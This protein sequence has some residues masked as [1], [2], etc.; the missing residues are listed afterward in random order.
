MENQNRKQSQYLL[1]RGRW[2]GAGLALLLV[3]LAGC[4]QDIPSADQSSSG[5]SN[6]T[7]QE[8]PEADAE[9]PQSPDSAPEISPGEN[10]NSP[11][12]GI[13]P[14]D[15]LSASE[16]EAALTEP[17]SSID[18][19]TIANY[20]SCDYRGQSGGK[21]ITLQVTR[22]TAEQFKIDNEE[23]SAMFEVELIPVEDLGDEAAFYSGLLRVRVGET[24]LQIATWHTVEEEDQALA[25]TQELAR[26]A[27]TR[28]P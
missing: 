24:V 7:G 12:T 20:E 15:L 16:A 25:L 6:L 17:V 22:Q 3:L 8:S 13:N 27:L 1:P 28:L 11:S 23:T 14:C 5:V 2:R 9:L 19:T 21:F 4:A 18:Q 10:L 26:I